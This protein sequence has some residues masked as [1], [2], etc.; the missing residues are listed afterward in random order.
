MLAAGS[1]K[2]PNL[3]QMLSFL[4]SSSIDELNDHASTLIPLVFADGSQN[5]GLRLSLANGIWL[6]KSVLVKPC[7]KQVMDTAYKAT[8]HNVDFK[9]NPHEVNSWA[10]K[11]TNG[12]V[13]E[14]LPLGLVHSKTRLILSN[15]VYVL[16]RYL[17]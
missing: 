9:T 10:K 3:D 11:Q 6:D 5:G 15:A 2:G 17:G 7:F 8:L 13:N 12:L 16:Q 4:K 14:I 1:T